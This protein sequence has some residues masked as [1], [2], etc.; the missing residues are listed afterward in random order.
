V[1][2]V[3]IPSVRPPPDHDIRLQP[4]DRDP[5]PLHDLVLIAAGD[6]TVGIVPQLDA[7]R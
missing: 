5:N 7:I 2:G 6:S 3:P 1:V 4:L